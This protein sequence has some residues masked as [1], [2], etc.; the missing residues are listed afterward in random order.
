MDIFDMV[1]YALFLSILS[2]AT[3]IAFGLKLGGVV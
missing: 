1:V 2:F 3:V